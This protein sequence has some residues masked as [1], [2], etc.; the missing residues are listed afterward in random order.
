MVQVQAQND[1][2]VVLNATACP[3]WALL[4]CAE[5]ACQNFPKPSS[6]L[7]SVLGSFGIYS[8]PDSKTPIF[9]VF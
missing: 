9:D 6:K 4:P 5:G 8:H 7:N 1:L 3:A 2:S